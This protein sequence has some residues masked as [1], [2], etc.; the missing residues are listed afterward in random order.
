MHSYLPTVRVVGTTPQ[1]RDGYLST[2]ILFHIAYIFCVFLTRK[3]GA[4]GPI[5]MQA[6]ER[7][8]LAEKIDPVG[9]KSKQKRLRI[10]SSMRMGYKNE[11]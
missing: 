2:H 7:I 4:H 3:L 1:A 5:L 10:R 8:A 9:A 6:S 11:H